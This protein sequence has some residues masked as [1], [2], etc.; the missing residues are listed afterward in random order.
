MESRFERAGSLIEIEIEPRRGPVQNKARRKAVR[1][2]R[3]ERQRRVVMRAVYDG[4]EPDDAGRW[5]IQR[6]LQVER[7]AQPQEEVGRC[8][9]WCSGSEMTKMATR[10]RILG[11]ASL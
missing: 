7:P 11:L 5:A 4:L 2:E 6:I 8:R 10:G 9:S 3:R 1:K